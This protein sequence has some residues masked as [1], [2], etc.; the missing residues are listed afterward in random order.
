MTNQRGGLSEI[1]NIFLEHGIIFLSN[2]FSN[3]PKTPNQI[4]GQKVREK[5]FRCDLSFSD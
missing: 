1:T 5:K 4:K 2:I 3:N